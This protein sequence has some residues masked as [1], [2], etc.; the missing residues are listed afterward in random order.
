[1]QILNNPYLKNISLISYILL[2]PLMVIAQKEDNYEKRW[3]EINK[4]IKYDKPR[5]SS[6][7]KDDFFTPQSLDEDRR[8]KSSVEKPPPSDEDIIYTR[9]KN[10][11]NGSDRGVEKHIKEGESQQIKDLTAPKADA[12]ERQST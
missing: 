4:G 8:T 12:P 3:S 1:M 5:Q 6:G 10:Y 7:P 11:A 2:F 9:E